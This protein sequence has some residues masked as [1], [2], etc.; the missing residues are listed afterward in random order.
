[1]E[2]ARASVNHNSYFNYSLKLQNRVLSRIQ[3]DNYTL[4][5]VL[6]IIH[7]KV[8]PILLPLS[9]QAKKLRRIANTVNVI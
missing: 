3:R 1:M 6:L 7:S 5:S 9:G 4:G 8:I 2:R